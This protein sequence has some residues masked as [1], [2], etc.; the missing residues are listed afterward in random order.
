[1]QRFVVGRGFLLFC[2]LLL[3]EINIILTVQDQYLTVRNHC[4]TVR[5]Q[6]ETVRPFD[7]ECL[8]YVGELNIH[9]KQ[10]SLISIYKRN[11]ELEL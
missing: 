7:R 6:R 11:L 1:M 10:K 8:K 4:F 2:K 9:R 5:D 3:Y